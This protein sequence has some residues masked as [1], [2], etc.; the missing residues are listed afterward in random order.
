MP[1]KIGDLEADKG[2][3]R[4]PTG[5]PL[6]NYT[7]PKIRGYRRGMSGFVFLLPH[8]RFS[9]KCARRNQGS[10]EA[11]IKPTPHKF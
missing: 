9:S 3:E 10:D 8:P 1:F 11:V 4:P 7:S 2:S 6:I 5:D